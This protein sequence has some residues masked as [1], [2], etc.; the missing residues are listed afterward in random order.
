MIKI[1]ETHEEKRENI[2]HWE[3]M[4]MM[5][6]K[7]RDEYDRVSEDAYHKK[8]I[9]KLKLSKRPDFMEPVYTLKMSFW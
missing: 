2:L 9:L 3:R 6:Q 4:R 7:I 5:A 1:A 8:F